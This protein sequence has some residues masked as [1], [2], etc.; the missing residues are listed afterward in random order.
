MDDADGSAVGPVA[1]GRSREASGGSAAPAR[2]VFHDEAPMDVVGKVA[3]PVDGVLPEVA[4]ALE[5]TAVTG[6]R[7][8]RRANAE[9]VVAAEAEG[10]NMECL[11]AVELTDCVAVI[12]RPR[13]TVALH[14]VRATARG[15]EGKRRGAPRAT[16]S[17]ARRRIRVPIR[18]TSRGPHSTVEI[19][20]RRVDEA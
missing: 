1:T 13:L 18:G 16:K 11:L 12:R 7:P 8:R 14:N 2:G 9:L 17:A 19:R 5:P 4:V 10:R 15:P 3:T 6:A 20:S